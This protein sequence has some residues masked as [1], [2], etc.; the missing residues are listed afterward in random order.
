[1]AA[2]QNGKL[3]S[4]KYFSLSR[5]MFICSRLGDGVDGGVNTPFKFVMAVVLKSFRET[6]GPKEYNLINIIIYQ[7]LLVKS[8]NIDGRS[9]MPNMRIVIVVGF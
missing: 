4:S 6:Y 9:Q 8:Q 3:Y 2:S 5:A 7:Q 1:V